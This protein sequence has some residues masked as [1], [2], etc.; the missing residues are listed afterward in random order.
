[1]ME[2]SDIVMSRGENKASEDEELWHGCKCKHNGGEMGRKP[3][4]HEILHH[5]FVDSLSRV[6]HVY[7]AFAILKVGLFGDVGECSC[8]VKVEA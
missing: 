1:M 5:E 7:L 6:G 2:D 3:H 8:M 4:A